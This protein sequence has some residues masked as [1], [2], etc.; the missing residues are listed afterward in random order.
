[1]KPSISSAYFKMLNPYEMAETF[2]ECGYWQTE[3]NEE[4]FKSFYKELDV[5]EYRRFIDD[6]GFSIPQG[7]L[8]FMNEGNIT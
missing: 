5:R 7:H 3:I 4:H 1:M 6:L 8:V 2:V